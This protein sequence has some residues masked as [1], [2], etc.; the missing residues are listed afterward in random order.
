MNYLLFF[1]PKDPAGTMH[2]LMFN[3]GEWF[4]VVFFPTRSFGQLI[5]HKLTSG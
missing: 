4:M 3:I 1:C 5:L 2:K